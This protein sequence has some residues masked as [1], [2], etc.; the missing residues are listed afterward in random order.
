MSSLFFTLFSGK[1]H[2]KPFY[3]PFLLFKKA[4]DGLTIHYEPFYQ[5]IHAF[6]QRV[7]LLYEKD[8]ENSKDNTYR[9]D[10]KE[11]RNFSC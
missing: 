10:C 8:E 6:H 7:N 11:V 9:P 2:F 5:L 4:H 3:P 1:V